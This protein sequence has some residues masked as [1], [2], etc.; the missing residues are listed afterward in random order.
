MNKSEAWARKRLPENI[1]LRNPILRGTQ[2]P[3][4]FILFENMLH[5]LY[6]KPIIYLEKSRFSP[7]GMYWKRNP[8]GTWARIRNEF[9]FADKRQAALARLYVPEDYTVVKKI[10]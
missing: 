8:E 5:N 3:H 7:T 4:Q 2:H 1:R 9:L 6:G 10:I